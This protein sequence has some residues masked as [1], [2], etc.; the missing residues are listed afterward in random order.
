MK[1][2]VRLGGLCRPLATLVTTLGP[3]AALAHPGDHPHFRGVHLDVPDQA[4]GL[5]AIAVLVGAVWW[6][7]RH[8][9]EP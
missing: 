5:A 3:V 2:G 9:D 8:R 1:H 4:W 6:L 7:R